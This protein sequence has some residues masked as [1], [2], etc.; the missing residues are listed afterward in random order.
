M[1]DASEC[2]DVIGGGV[3]DELL[4]DCK[5][6]ACVAAEGDADA[7]ADAVSSLFTDAVEMVC[8]IPDIADEFLPEKLVEETMPPTTDYPTQEPTTSSPTTTD[9]PTQEPTTSS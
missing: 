5:Y 7:I 9:Y 6:D 4:E 3:C 2:C 1:E 8:D